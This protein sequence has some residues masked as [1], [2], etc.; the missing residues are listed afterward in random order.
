MS[1]DYDILFL[2]GGLN[3]AGAVVAAKAGLRTAL[4]EKN[5]AHLGGTCLHNGCIPSKMYLHAAETLRSAR[6][7]HFTGA[8][9][10]DMARLDDEKE[11][12][13]AAATKAITKQCAEVDLIDGEGVLSAPHTVTVANRTVRARHIVIGTGARPFIPE[14]IVYDGEGVITSDEVLNMR[15][16]PEKISIYGSGAIGL[17]MASFFAGAGVQTELIWRGDVLLKNAHPGISKNIRSQCEQ[18]GIELRPAHPI[19][20]AK[21][22]KRGVHIVFENGHEH[23]VPIL[24]VATGR[25]AVTEAV[26]TDAV[27]IG[28]KGIETD[29]HFETTLRD[30]Y[31][32]GDCNGKLQLAHAARAEVL[33]VVRRILGKNPET[34]R[35]ENIV[36]FIHTLPSSYACVGK[37]RTVLE[38]EG[39]KF[40]ESIVPLRGLPY[41]HIHDAD[42]GM[43]AVYSDTENFIVGAELFA[44]NAEE[45]AGIVA[46]ALAA[47]ADATLAKRTVLAHPTFS[48]SLEKSFLRL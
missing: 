39:V 26:A 20:R 3:Y 1:D 41:A 33:Y 31:A 37:T 23:Y 2:G 35:P 6:Q 12:M 18:L 5:M 16:L 15:T 22:T 14:G 29:T 10:L 38:R 4:V 21:M 44:P 9:Q 47:E 42:L 46:M 48:E 24:L 19:D 13:L 7:A 11:A 32:V 8:L 28:R 43:M 36:R 25:R 45:L 17:E 34:I 40:N 30:H 27:R